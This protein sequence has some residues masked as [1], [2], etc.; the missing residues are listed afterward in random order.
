MCSNLTTYL[1][2]Y[3]HV[4]DPLME[5]SSARKTLDTDLNFGIICTKWRVENNINNKVAPSLY[6]L[7][8][9]DELVVIL[10]RK[11]TLI[12]DQFPA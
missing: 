7:K 2:K 3:L 6:L 11:K 12:L 10:S 5:E 9:L 8:L 4:F 1:I